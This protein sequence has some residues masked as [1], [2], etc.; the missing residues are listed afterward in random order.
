M[1][2]SRTSRFSPGNRY[3]GYFIRNDE[4]QLVLTAARDS[5]ASEKYQIAK[6]QVYIRQ[7]EYH[8]PGYCFPGK[9]PVKKGLYRGT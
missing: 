8:R 4:D 9:G 6:E 3:T 1:L 7:P 5:I 2:W